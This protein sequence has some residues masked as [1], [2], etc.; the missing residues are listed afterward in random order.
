MKWAD[1]Q[2]IAHLCERHSPSDRYA[3]WHDLRNDEAGAR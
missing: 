3:G 2:Y 1:I